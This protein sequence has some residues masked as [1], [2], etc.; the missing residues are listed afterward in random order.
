MEHAAGQRDPEV[1]F[2]VLIVV[3]RQRR[4]PV[5]GTDAELLQRPGQ[6]PRARGEIG[7]GVSVNRPV[8]AAR[9]DRPAREDALG[10]P[11]NGRERE[12]EVHHQTVHGADCRR[13]RLLSQAAPRFDQFFAPVP[14]F[15][16]FLPHDSMVSETPIGN[17]GIEGQP[18]AIDRPWRL[19]HD[20]GR[21]EKD[22][23]VDRGL[24]VV[25]FA[26]TASGRVAAPQGVV[27]QRN[28]SLPMA[29]TIAEASLAECKSKGF[30][31]RWRW[32]TAPA[33]CW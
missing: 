9:D 32:S 16:Q 22:P 33:R 19:R 17:G 4:D 31:T 15:D 1:R 18:S 10:A 6:P 11:E 12:G 24:R 21:F 7:E 3:P 20:H 25:R 8:R 23:R 5:A 13:K 2:E 29:R 30:N 26:P 28:L 27:M 14:R